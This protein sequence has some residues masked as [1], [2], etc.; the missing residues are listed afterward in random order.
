MAE[1]GRC[2]RVL[3][4][5]TGTM[6]RDEYVKIKES[7]DIARLAWEDSRRKLASRS[8]EKGTAATSP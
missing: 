4:A 1:Y 3:E 8:T 5:Y 2:V 6:M 7:A